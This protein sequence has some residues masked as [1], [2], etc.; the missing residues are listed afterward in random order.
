MRDLDVL[1]DRDR[2]GTVQV[3]QL[4]A[5]SSSSDWMEV[6]RIRNA[7][8]SHSQETMAITELSGNCAEPVDRAQSHGTQQIS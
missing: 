5:C 8:G 6:N 4:P 1:K 2:A 3:A 7:K